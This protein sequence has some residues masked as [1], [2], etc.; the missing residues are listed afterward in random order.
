MIK[1]G[2][3]EGTILS[4]A[5][6]QTKAGDPQAVI[7]FAID[8]NGLPTPVTWF[9]SFKV[10]KA[11][12]ITIKTLITCG[13]KGN[14]PGGDLEIGKKVK[15]VLEEVIRDGKTSVQVRWVNPLGEI[16]NVMPNDLAKSKLS[17]LEGAVMLARN[18]AGVKHHDEDSIPF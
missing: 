1:A 4:H 5:I 3:Y 18:K 12:E 7:K 15:L 6:S 17:A 13:L 16:R 11:Q 8:V 9:G 2:T 14:N 10:G